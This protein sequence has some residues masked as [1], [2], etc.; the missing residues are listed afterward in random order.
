LTGA[1]GFYCLTDYFA[2]KIE[3]VE[4]ITEEKEG[5]QMLEVARSVGIKHLIWSTLPEVKERS[6]GKYKHVYHFDGKHR[7]EQYARKL[8]FEIASYVAPSCY[9]QNFTGGATRVVLSS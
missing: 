4:D 8:G 1:Y 5:R 6:G 3:K 7:V 9:M 2:H